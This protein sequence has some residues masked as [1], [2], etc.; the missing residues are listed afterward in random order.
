MCPVSCL[1][2]TTIPK[3]SH[4]E[5]REEDDENII[6]QI[7]L[8]KEWENLYPGQQVHTESSSA[9]ASQGTSSEVKIKSALLERVALPLRCFYWQHQPAPG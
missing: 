6:S 1:G 8:T 2:K 4:T 9:K 3:S 5:K 7:T